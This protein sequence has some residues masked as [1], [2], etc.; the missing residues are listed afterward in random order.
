M[1]RKVLSISSKDHDVVH[2]MDDVRVVEGFLLKR[3]V[4]FTN[5]VFIECRKICSEIISIG[6]LSIA[7][8]KIGH[9]ILILK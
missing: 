5:I 4:F 7:V 2:S 6:A 8:M 1:S 9:V 3:L